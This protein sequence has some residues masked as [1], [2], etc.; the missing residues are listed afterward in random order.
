MIHQRPADTLYIDAASQRGRRAG[1]Q[2]LPPI[3]PRG[4]IEA[5][6]ARLYS[7]AL[8]RECA[9]QIAGQCP[10]YDPADFPGF[11]REQIERDLTARP[12]LNLDV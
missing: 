8:D 6:L 1:D 12:I 11:T 5:R 2:P 4:E 9:Y 10:P 3:L 7:E